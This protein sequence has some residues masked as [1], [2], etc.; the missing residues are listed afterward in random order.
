MSQK[1]FL[2]GLVAGVF[3]GAL[4]T[5]GI[6]MA[7]W[8]MPTPPQ[9]RYVPKSDIAK[10]EIEPKMPPNSNRRFFNGSPYYIVPLAAKTIDASI[11][12]NDISR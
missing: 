6:G 10:P 3:L 4:F 7:F 8:P 12:A 1:S 5:M 9:I 11:A 2:S